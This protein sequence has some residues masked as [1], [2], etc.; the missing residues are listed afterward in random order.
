VYQ[1]EA[2]L[3]KHGKKYE[4][5]HYGGAANGFFY[6]HRRL[7]RLEPRGRP[8]AHDC[9]RCPVDCL[10]ARGNRVKYG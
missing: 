4:F 6:W 8:D 1:H 7:Y 10:S 5:C 3:E 2:E 9:L